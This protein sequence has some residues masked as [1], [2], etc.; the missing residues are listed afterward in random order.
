MY[1]QILSWLPFLSLVVAVLAV[2]VGPLISWCVAMR[3]LQTSLRVSNKQIIAPMR[4]AWINNLRELVAELSGK[5]AHYWAAGYEDRDDAEYRHITELVH[6]LE[7]YINSAEA[8]HAAL[9][10][11]VRIME[12]LLSAGSNQE[13]DRT[14]WEA[15]H[16]VMELS[17]KILK[18]EWDRVKENI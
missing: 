4:Q 14:F 5:C 9:L 18:R 10:A 2:V 6:K 1:H 3:Q 8:D 7:L 11:Q 17:Q 12:Q 16:R 13:T 15:H